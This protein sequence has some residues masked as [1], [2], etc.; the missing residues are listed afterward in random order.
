MKLAIFVDQV[1]WRDGGVLSTDESYIHFPASF[2]EPL[3]E[4]VFIGRVAPEPGRGPYILDRPGISLCP[5]PYYPNLYQLWRMHPKNYGLIR[6]M[7]RD[8]ARTWD[9][10]L[11]AGPHPIGQWIVARECIKLG[12]PVGLIV[13][14]N[15]IE[16]MG[17]HRGLKRVAA[18]IA[19][20]VLEWDFKRLAKGRIVFTVGM[21][22]ANEYGRYSDRVYNHFPC[23]VDNAQFRMF[24]A[25]STGADPS[26]LL[27]VG[28]LAP[29]KGHRYLFEALAQL[30]TRGL[31]CNLDIVGSGPLEEECR[32]R[33]KSLGLESQ[34][35]FHGYVPYGPD[36]FNLYQR[37]GAMIV[38]S[39]TEG[40]PQVINESLCIGLPTIA[41]SVGGIPSFLKDGETALLVPPADVNA[42]AAA[43]ERLVHDGRLRESLR[44]NGRALMENNTLEENRTRFLGGI[45]R[46]L[47]IKHA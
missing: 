13:K 3:G 19:A 27:C 18:T 37:A 4:I 11:I 32:S 26:R 40:L 15:F 36:L 10:V 46:D 24:S 21:E 9:A 22:M 42:L 17:A 6:E 30:N 47:F 41:T 31:R 28:R 5:L 7:I 43:I 34:V 44:R 14:Q 23:L 12:V 35:T 39:L 20:R 25:M 1:F 38:S 33:V 45:R 2:A 29:E 16:Q 8:N